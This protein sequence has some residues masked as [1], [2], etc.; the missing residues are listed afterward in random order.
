MVTKYTSGSPLRR[1]AAARDLQQA[2]HQALA[3]DLMEQNEALATVVR[4]CGIDGGVQPSDFG[5]LGAAGGGI[6]L[7]CEHPRWGKPRVVF[8]TDSISR[9]MNEVGG[10]LKGAR[11]KVNWRGQSP[12]D[13]SKG[14]CSIIGSSKERY[15]HPDQTS[16][17]SV[18][19]FHGTYTNPESNAVFAGSE[20][21]G[22]S[23]G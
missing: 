18:G 14:S 5:I 8:C 9:I 15:S 13:I 22:E 19:G 3:P 12:S 11:V 16:P 6:W 4:W 10:N 7:E 21:S 2:K 1:G 17:V 20:Y 23:G